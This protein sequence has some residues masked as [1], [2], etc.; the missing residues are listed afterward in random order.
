MKRRY[1]AK[2]LSF[3]AGPIFLLSSFARLAASQR[4][5]KRD[6]SILQR[7][8]PHVIEARPAVS[9]SNYFIASLVRLRD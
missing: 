3:D 6:Y 4:D 8:Q 1:E 9:S 5:S 7:H 2:Y